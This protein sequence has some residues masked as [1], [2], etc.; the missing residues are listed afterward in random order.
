MGLF[1]WL[2]GDRDSEPD[3]HRVVLYDSP[4]H[5]FTYVVLMLEKVCGLPHTAGYNLAKLVDES[6]SAV[7]FTGPLD[8]CERVCRLI[9]EHGPDPEVPSSASSMLVE[10]EPA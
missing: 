7:V 6:G 10:I 8:E 1:G 4:H 5:G 3:R 9:R 2:W